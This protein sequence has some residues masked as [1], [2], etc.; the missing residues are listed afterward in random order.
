MKKINNRRK[1]REMVMKSIYRG[2]LNSFDYAQIKKDIVEDPD[3]CRCDESLYYALLEG[4]ELNYD[5]I[6]AD[7][8]NFTEKKIKEFNPIE[9]YIIIAS[10]YELKFRID[11]PFKVTINEALEITKSF[12]GE[13]SYK[14]ING[15]LDQ[16]AKKYRALEVN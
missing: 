9:L 11:I 10:Y 6:M 5:E 4:V 15:M 12:G 14:F 8:E 2:L 13:E 16:V 1:S 7:I 3:F